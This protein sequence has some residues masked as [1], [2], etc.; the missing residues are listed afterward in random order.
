MVFSI[1]FPQSWKDAQHLCLRYLYI[2]NSVHTFYC[3]FIFLK[4]RFIVSFCFLP[5][6]GTSNCKLYS[7]PLKYYFFR[8]W[9]SLN[10]KAKYGNQHS[11]HILLFSGVFQEIDFVYFSTYQC[12]EISKFKVKQDQC[13]YQL[14]TCRQRTIYGNIQPETKLALNFLIK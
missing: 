2:K 5:R 6:I 8:I 1:Q 12:I 4:L 9:R 13:E 7:Y 14:S 3:S 10:D 11:I